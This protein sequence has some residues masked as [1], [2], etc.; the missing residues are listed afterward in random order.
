M[1]NSALRIDRII[2]VEDDIPHRMRHAG[3]GWKELVQ[4]WWARPSSQGRQD[5]RRGLTRSTPRFS[6]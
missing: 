4:W 3:R 2:V 6:M 5:N 1:V